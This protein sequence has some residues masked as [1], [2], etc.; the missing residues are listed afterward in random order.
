MYRPYCKCVSW[1]ALKLTYS[2]YFITLRTNPPPSPQPSLTWPLYPPSRVPTIIFSIYLKDKSEIVRTLAVK[3]S[4]YKKHHTN[5]LNLLQIKQEITW[6]G[7][8]VCAGLAEGEPV[9]LQVSVL[10]GESGHVDD[11]ELTTYRAARL[12]ALSQGRVKVQQERPVLAGRT[13]L[14]FIV[15]ALDFFI[16]PFL[17]IKPRHSPCSSCRNL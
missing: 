12:W 3:K 9:V 8:T 4:A 11:R 17:Q 6:V 1:G 2:T 16:V 5:T 14:V 15:I 7:P 13:S 10:G